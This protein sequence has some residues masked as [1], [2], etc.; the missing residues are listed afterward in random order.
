MFTTKKW[1]SGIVV[2]VILFV[3]AVSLAGCQSSPA[4]N[5]HTDP[6]VDMF[7]KNDAAVTGAK[8]LDITAVD[9]Q[10]TSDNYTFLMKVNGAI[11]AVTTGADI[12]DEWAFMIDADTNINTGMALSLMVNNMDFGFIAND[13]GYDYMAHFTLSKSLRTFEVVSNKTGKHTSISGSVNGNIVSLTVPASVIGDTQKF[14]WTA[15]VREFT[16]GIYSSTPAVSDKAP[17]HGHFNYPVVAATAAPDTSTYRG[18]LN[19]TW[20]LDTWLSP[21]PVPVKGTVSLNILPDGNVEGTFGGDFSGLL[22]GTIDSDGHVNFNG[23]HKTFYNPLKMQFSGDVTKKDNIL[24]LTGSY[25]LAGN[26]GGKLTAIGNAA[27]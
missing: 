20:S 22:I 5:G 1:I 9:M 16:N 13:I 2:L 11:P 12:Y 17:N 25:T 4:V 3:A 15:A 27:P 19:G 7:D 24:T 10:K 26:A 23:F 8:Y 14:Y 18:T 6:A 21:P